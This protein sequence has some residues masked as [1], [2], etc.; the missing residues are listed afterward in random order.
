MERRNLRQNPF[1]H[2]PWELL[3]GIAVC[4]PDLSSVSNLNEACPAFATIFNRHGPEILE[5][6]MEASLPIEIRGVIRLTVYLR[7]LEEG[8]G[9]PVLT[10]NSF[11]DHH[12]F[13][14]PTSRAVLPLPANT[15]PP[16]LRGILATAVQIEALAMSCLA[17]F[18][19]RCLALHP[20]HLV[21]KTFKYKVAKSEDNPAGLAYEPHSSGPPSWLERHYTLHAF[22]HVQIYV[23]LVNAVSRHRISRIDSKFARF[24]HML[25]GQLGRLAVIV[26]EYPCF[27]AGWQIDCPPAQVFSVVE[28]LEDLNWSVPVL[29]EPSHEIQGASVHLP[30]PP[31]AEEPFDWEHTGTG[32]FPGCEEPFAFYSPTSLGPGM[33]KGQDFCGFYLSWLPSPILGVENLGSLTRRPSPFRRLGMLFWDSRRLMALELHGPAEQ[34][35]FL[36]SDPFKYFGV[37]DL[38]F[39]WKSLLTPQ[40]LV[41]Q[42]DGAVE[43]M[44]RRTGRDRRIRRG[45][46]GLGAGSSTIDP[47]SLGLTPDASRAAIWAAFTSRHLHN[48]EG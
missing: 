42:K 22:W 38:F 46:N 43:L 27:T 39:T 13:S 1:D 29:E 18:M 28:Y 36:A 11:I 8:D 31:L 19:R 12:M 20:E 25:L 41:I 33:T 47:V 26:Q 34:D 7:D 10:L 45:A 48:G 9:E 4:L 21:D 6:V 23:D 2:V 3:L 15:S 35:G 5:S 30:Q 44:R 17:E 14:R 32:W 16:L 24:E 37:H 40:Q